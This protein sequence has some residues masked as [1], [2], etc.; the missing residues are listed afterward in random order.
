MLAALVAGLMAWILW[1]QLARTSCP[2]IVRVVLL[3]AVLG[4]PA[5]LFLAT[6]ALSEM[7]ALLLFLIA[8]I[9][10]LNFTRAGDT[11]SGFVAGLALGLAFFA[12]H[13]ALLY[14]LA[15][16]MFTP[17][18]IRK[19]GRAGAVAAAFVLLFP[20]VIA[21]LS[22]CY[23]NWIFT[24]DPL[25]FTRDAGS[26][27]FVYS[28]AAVEDLPIGWPEALRATGRNLLSSPLYLAI[29]VIVMFLQPARLPAFLVPAVL[30]IG[31]RAWGL[32]YPDYFAMTTLA[33]VALAALHRRT[34]ATLWPVLGLAAVVHLWAGYATPLGGEPAAWMRAVR[35]GRPAP[36][37]VAEVK[38]AGHLARFPQGSV[39]V[40]DR[41]AHRVVS[42]A[43]TA[44]PFLLPADPLYALAETRP[45]AFVRYV[46]VARRSPECSVGRF[47]TACT[48]NLPWGVRPVAVWEGWALYER[49]PDLAN[50][51]GPS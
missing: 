30:I 15:Y 25:A 21:V 42:R 4:V 44:R 23:A 7:L 38:V 5:S 46:L 16:A 33:V 28:A 10:F 18:F 19:R 6:Q 3:A 51:P 50:A 9:G 11:P 20:V 17:M 26:S 12:S 32:V 24:G 1:G 40:D 49:W 13:Y 43:G 36:A 47:S 2:V 31:V 35:T 48:T 22:W 41:V 29:G 14:G 8:W 37:D 34:P 45:A 39:L 27:L